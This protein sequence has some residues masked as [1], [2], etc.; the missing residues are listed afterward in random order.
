M[1]KRRDDATAGRPGCWSVDQ[2]R[3][4][5][6]ASSKRANDPPLRHASS[7]LLVGRVTQ[8]GGFF[9][10]LAMGRQSRSWTC[11]VLARVGATLLAAAL[12]ILAEGLITTGRKAARHALNHA[13]LQMLSTWSSA[14]EAHRAR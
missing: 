6:A 11:T 10:H 4:V 2:Q 5:V 9:V 8:S 14:P 1:R 13:I 12:L 3:V 7:L